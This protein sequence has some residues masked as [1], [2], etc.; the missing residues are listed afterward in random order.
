[1]KIK[2]CIFDLDGTL[3]DTLADIRYYLNLM[4]VKYSLPEI[5]EGQAKIFVGNGAYN[6]VCRAAE[7]GGVDIT[8]DE[9]KALCRKICDEFVELYDSN[10]NYLTAPYEGICENLLKLRSLGKRLCVLSNKPDSMV[11][12]LVKIHFGDIFEIVRGATSDFPLK[13]DPTAALD[14]CRELGVLPSETAY[15][16]DT[17]TDIETG[18]NYGAAKTVGVAWGFRDASELA[19]AG[20][21]TVISCASEFSVADF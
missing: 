8:T 12:K 6:L 19:S 21:D 17:S 4:L 11:K 2:A 16:G 13:P 7:S 18:L 1:M 14:I 5:S 3:L 9:G 15:F 20:A 10:P